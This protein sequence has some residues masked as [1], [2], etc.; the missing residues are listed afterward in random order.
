MASVSD[1]QVNLVCRERIQHVSLDLLHARNSL[2]YRRDEVFKSFALSIGR[3]GGIAT[4]YTDTLS[5]FVSVNGIPQINL[6]RNPAGLLTL[7]FQLR[8][9][10]DGVLVEMIDNWFTAYPHNLHDMI[11]TP[12]TKEVTV[13]LA[14][15]DV[16]LEFSFRRISPNELNDV[17]KQDWDRS[18]E[19]F[20]QRKKGWLDRLPPDVRG[21][22]E[23]C[24]RDRPAGGRHPPFWLK[25]LAR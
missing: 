20:A 17:L 4:P 21:F 1:R 10:D 22:L 2:K 14:K 11:V 7:S 23:R 3:G 16:G 13:W 19:R 8:N 15:E 25:E 24:D 12:K 9:A 18:R 5:P 6:G